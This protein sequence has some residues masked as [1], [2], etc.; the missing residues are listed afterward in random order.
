VVSVEA[1]TLVRDPIARRQ[2]LGDRFDEAATYAARVHAGQLR[3]G[4][5]EPYIEHLLR[6]ASLVIDDGGSEEEAIAALLHDAP[7]DQGGRGRLWDI[8]RRF[9]PQVTEIVDALTDTYD[10]PRPPWRARKERY[11]TH[12]DD[13]PAALRVSMA[14][15]VDNVRALTRDYRV[16]GE[17]LWPRSGKAPDDVRWYYRALA[18]RFSVL[19]PGRLAAELSEAVSELEDVIDGPRAAPASRP[20]S[21]KVSARDADHCPRCGWSLAR[22]LGA[23]AGDGGGRRAICP[24]CRIRLARAPEAPDRSWRPVGRAMPRASR[25][26]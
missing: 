26:A 17:E 4:T 10:D 14:D 19:R 16:Q 23:R 5:E 11:L 15:K 7:E 1:Q 20:G 9:G 6:V 18:E 8:R 24:N 13:S 21:G 3:A 22:A 25:L 2:A 12:L